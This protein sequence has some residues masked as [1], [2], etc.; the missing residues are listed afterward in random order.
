MD[1]SFLSRADQVTLQL[2][3]AKTAFEEAKAKLDL[4]KQAYDALLAEADEH[5]IPKAKLKKLTEDRVQALLD[6]GI[7]A[8]FG[9]GESKAAIEPKRE[10]PKKTTKK[11]EG[12]LAAESELADDEK[13]SGKNAREESAPVMN[14]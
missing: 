2:E 13:F 14:A 7:L 3:L 9:A 11:S 5:G 12:D 8:S 10:R 4:A 6:S 1:L